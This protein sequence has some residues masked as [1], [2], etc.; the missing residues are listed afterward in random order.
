MAK[1]ICFPFLAL[2]LFGDP[3]RQ[4]VRSQT[5]LNFV[6]M[7]KTFSGVAI[8]FTVCPMVVAC[9]AV[10]R[11]VMLKK[12]RPSLVKVFCIIAKRNE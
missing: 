1:F 5:P 10:A 11:V 8:Q 2:T 3:R 7:A 4:F 12:K 9:D 6:S